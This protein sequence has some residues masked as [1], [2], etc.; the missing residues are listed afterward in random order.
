[1]EAA[2]DA[3]RGRAAGRPGA[4]M[5]RELNRSITARRDWARDFPA[6]TLLKVANDRRIRARLGRRYE[7]SLDAHRPHLP[8]LG[9][10]EQE[11]V[12]GLEAEGVVVTSLDAL[13]VPNSARVI[14]AARAMADDYAQEARRRVAG[15]ADFVVVPPERIAA[16]PA[17]FEW[18]LDDRLLDVVETYLGLPVAYDGVCLNYTV[19]DGREVSTRKWHRDWEDRRMLKIALYLNDVD[20]GGGPFQLIRRLDTGQNDVHG[21]DYGLADDEELARRL[22]EGVGEDVVSCEG[23]A[24]TVFFADTARFFHRGKPATT[25]DRAA[26]FFSY[27]ARRPRHPFFCERSGMSRRD[28]AAL[29][30]DL[31][32]RQ[33]AAAMWRRELPALMRLIP[34][35][36]V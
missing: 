32:P 13:R 28:I 20:E 15:G 35:A 36:R 25:R 29:A 14:A 4:T 18:G 33:R 16:E 21:F 31:P 34:P 8:R 1:M 30:A 24:G 22:G 26:L 2:S 17:I 10:L 6:R 12:A 3:A 9:R 27:F 5:V 19:A 7:A 11:I 23:P